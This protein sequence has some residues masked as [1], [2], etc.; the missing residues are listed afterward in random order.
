M[1]LGL[2][3]PATASSTLAQMT[4]SACK[5]FGTFAYPFRWYILAASVTLIA[6]LH[7]TV[8]MVAAGW[9]DI[10]AIRYCLRFD[11]PALAVSWAALC[12]VTWFPPDMPL[13]SPLKRFMARASVRNASDF[14]Q[15][16]AS[17]MVGL[18]AFVFPIAFVY[19][20]MFI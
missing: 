7:A 4:P 14:R 1:S 9:L 19:V 6:I 20:S 3:R 17:F 5:A 12:C 13:N 16:Q 15:W 10:R 11:G 2:M 18:I 8:L